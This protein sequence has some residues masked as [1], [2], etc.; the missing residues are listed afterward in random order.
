M[1]LFDSL[2]GWKTSRTEKRMKDMEMKGLCPECFGRGFNIYAVHEF[3]YEPPE[4][5][6]GCEGSGL[7]TDWIENT[8]Y[9]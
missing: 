3:M 4:L 6:N 2:A 5:C 1:S 9:H 8:Q 7:Y